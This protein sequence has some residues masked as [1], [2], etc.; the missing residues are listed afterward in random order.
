MELKQLEQ[1]DGLRFLG[2]APAK[3]VAL[4]PPP[5]SMGKL[6]HT[7]LW[8]IDVN[9]IPYIIESPVAGVARQLPKHTNLT[10]GREAY[11]GGEMWF[12]SQK[13]LCISGGSG[14]YPPTDEHQLQEA[15]EVFESFDYSVKSL[16]WDHI[17]GHARRYVQ[18]LI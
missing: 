10:G 7:Y 3:N 2:P 4:G 9:G 5:Y 1:K 6:E 16:G 8:V 15:A 13:S 12:T 14:R 11:L 18:A 17:E